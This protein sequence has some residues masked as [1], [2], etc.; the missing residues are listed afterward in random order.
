[1]H[2]I[3]GRLAALLIVVTMLV[4]AGGPA[5]AITYGQPD[6]GTP[7]LFPNVGALVDGDVA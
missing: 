7:P 5:Q 4:F 3:H 2:A 1:M 6:T